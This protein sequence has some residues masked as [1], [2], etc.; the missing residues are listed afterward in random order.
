MGRAL[1]V[2]PPEHPRREEATPEEVAAQQRAEAERAARE[3]RGEPEEPST[4]PALPPRASV[5]LEGYLGRKHDLE[6]AT[7]RASNRSWSTLYCVLRGGELAFYKD[8]KSRALGLPYHGEE[9]FALRNALCEV[10]AGYK[11][12]KHVFKLRLGNGSEWLFHGKDEEEMHTWLQ[13]LGTAIIESQS[14]KTKAQSLPLPLIT[15]VEPGLAKK[16][17]EKRFS[18]FPKKK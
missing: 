14:I 5:Q 7:K 2:L 16:D 10:A 1:H 18:F 8:A 4:L 9:P 17:K 15:A 11:K 3:A 12:R 6:A 13:S